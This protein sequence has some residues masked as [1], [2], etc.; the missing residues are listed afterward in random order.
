MLEDTQRSALASALAEAHRT[1]TPIPQP[2]AAHPGMD[3]DDAYAVQR[4]QIEEWVGS[5]DAV[6][7]YKIGLTSRAMQDQFGVRE[8]DFGV[9]IRSGLLLSGAPV[10]TGRFIA[11]KIEPE[12][13][14][15]L[16]Q[17][18]AGPGVTAL[19]ALAAIDHALASLEIIDSRV[20]DWRITVVDSVADNASF[21]AAAFG[22]RRIRW[23][24][25][26]PVL[27][28]CV[29]EVDGRTV[30]SGA[31]GA[32]LGNPLNALVWLANELGARGTVMRAGSV[33]MLGS[34]CAAVPV[35]AGQV[36]R[37]EFAGLG[38]VTLPFE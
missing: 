35:A 27:T 6:V 32:V 5:G 33:V 25:F 7:G 17:D 14:V 36:V 3:L 9:L 2:S 11:P 28:G 22:T 21:G 26:D 18:L 24:D 23:D 13:S 38:A 37:A 16:G 30:A 29:L 15:V 1:G 34:V 8:P 12:I 20:A 4:L 10:D 19:Q 31:G